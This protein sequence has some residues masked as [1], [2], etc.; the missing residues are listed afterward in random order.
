MDAVTDWKIYANMLLTIGIFTSVYSI[1]LFLPTIL[2][3]LGFSTNKSQLMTVP[4]YT[5]AFVSTIVGSYFADKS[6][7]RGVFL[8]GFELSAIM[9]FAMLR[10][11]GQASIQ[12]AGVFF[13]A[14]GMFHFAIYE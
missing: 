10:S 1:S 11:S 7:Q 8:L 14:G 12:Y 6:R 5:W 2:K 3:D 9:G 4:V 13:A